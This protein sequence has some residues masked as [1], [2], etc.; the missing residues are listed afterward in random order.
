M[1]GN[2]WRY[3]YN[4]LVFSAG[5]CVLKCVTLSFQGGSFSVAGGQVGFATPGL[6]IGWASKPWWERQSRCFGAGAGVGHGGSFCAG[7]DP[8]GNQDWGDWEFDYQWRPGGVYVGGQRTFHQ[9]A[10]PGLQWR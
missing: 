7:V 9:W 1:Y 4:H 10:P 2:W 3:L 8:H 5:F 6:G